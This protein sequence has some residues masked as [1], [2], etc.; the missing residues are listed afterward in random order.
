M[1]QDPSFADETQASLFD[2]LG[3]ETE[4]VRVLALITLGTISFQPESDVWAEV[5]EDK[6]LDRLL[7]RTT[8]TS[9]RARMIVFSAFR[10]IIFSANDDM[11]ARL[12]SK[13]LLERLTEMMKSETSDQ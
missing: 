7:E 11:L 4:R 8:D 9:Q 1:E 10:N 12:L 2:R 3:H 5:N 6:F 13:G